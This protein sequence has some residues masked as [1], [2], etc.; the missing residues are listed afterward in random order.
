MQIEVAF[1]VFKISSQKQ[2][3]K[4]LLCYGEAFWFSLGCLVYV[5]YE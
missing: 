3:K 5:D 2:Y 4:K 1:F